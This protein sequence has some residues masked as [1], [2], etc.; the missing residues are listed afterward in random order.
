ML[1]TQHDLTVLF[2]AR[3]NDFGVILEIIAHLK[4]LP[5]AHD[6]ALGVHENNMIR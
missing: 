6:A 4:Y 2:H 3:H 1:G 5:R